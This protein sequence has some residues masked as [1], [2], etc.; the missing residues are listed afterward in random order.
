M[1][2]SGVSDQSINNHDDGGGRGSVTDGAEREGECVVIL[3]WVFLLGCFVKL[4]TTLCKN[5]QH[6]GMLLFTHPTTNTHKT[7]SPKVA[8]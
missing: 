2:R 6:H 8:T 7:D 1:L 3:L 4:V 5:Y